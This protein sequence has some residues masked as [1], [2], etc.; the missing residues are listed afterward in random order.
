MFDCF[1]NCPEPIRLATIR[2]TLRIALSKVITDPFVRNP[3]AVNVLKDQTTLDIE[4]RIGGYLAQD[5]T[6]LRS[7][8]PASIAGVDEPVRDCTKL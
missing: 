7:A 8:T 5:S 6:S 2:H 1:E 3:A 4:F